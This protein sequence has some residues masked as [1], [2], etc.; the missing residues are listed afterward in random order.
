MCNITYLLRR[1]A[2]LLTLAPT[3]VRVNE[4]SVQSLTRFGKNFYI[5][6]RDLRS[7][8][9]GAVKHFREPANF[10]FFTT[11][12]CLRTQKARQ[13]LSKHRW[14][15]FFARPT[16]HILVLQDICR[17]LHFLPVIQV[18]IFTAASDGASKSQ[19]PR[20]RRRKT[21]ITRSQGPFT[22]S[23]PCLHHTFFYTN[24]DVQSLF[25]FFLCG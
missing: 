1:Q 19:T 2:Q 22:L 23:L 9:G 4:T 10:F 5:N 6:T 13:R 8:V 21:S 3:A 18:S 14:Q 16:G 25:H 7:G 15:L 12:S 11:R 24:I 17:L 20:T